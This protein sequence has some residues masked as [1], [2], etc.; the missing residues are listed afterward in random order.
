MIRGNGIKMKT[1]KQV[2][3]LLRLSLSYTYALLSK[4]G[5]K[6]RKRDGK[7]LT[8]T[9]NQFERV[10]KYIDKRNK[11]RSEEKSLEFFRKEYKQVSKKLDEIEKKVKA[12][13]KK[14]RELKRVG[15]KQLS[16]IKKKIAQDEKYCKKVLRDC[17]NR[18]KKKKIS[19][20]ERQYY[21]Y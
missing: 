9:Q 2:Q 17:K 15:K 20:M 18:G 3:E 1:I 21:G 13:R 5:I 7:V 10:K 8:I 6:P 11:R 12:Q 4:M 14:N 16:A 19:D